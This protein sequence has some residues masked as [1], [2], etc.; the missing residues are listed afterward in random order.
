MIHT[1]K[2]E[3]NILHTVKRKANW[4]VHILH[5]NRLL[6]L[7]TGERVEGRREVIGRRGR[8]SKQILGDLKQKKGCCK[9]KDEALDRTLWRTVLG[10]GCGPFV[11][12]KKELKG[13]RDIRVAALILKFGLSCK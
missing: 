13:S 1:V 6:K 7:V 4:T 2:K 11:R 3:G 10:R 12:Q 8:R 5:R 9:L